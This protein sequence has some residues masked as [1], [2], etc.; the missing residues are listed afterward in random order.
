MSYG[1][2]ESDMY[3]MAQHAVAKGYGKMEYF[4]AQPI[5]RSSRVTTTASAMSA[6]SPVVARTGRGGGSGFAI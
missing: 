1:D 6:S 5:A 3:S 4:R 2:I